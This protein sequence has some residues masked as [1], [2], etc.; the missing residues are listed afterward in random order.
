MARVTSKDRKDNP[1]DKVFLVTL[2]G[3]VLVVLGAFAAIVLP[4]F[5]EE[6]KV[7]SE[8]SIVKGNE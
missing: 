1:G 5:A 8:A 4:A 7:P 6:G 3:I 2:G